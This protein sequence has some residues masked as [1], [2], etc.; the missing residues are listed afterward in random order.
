MNRLLL[1][2]LP[3]FAATMVAANDAA[4]SESQPDDNLR[5]ENG[6][7]NICYND[8][9][10]EAFVEVPTAGIDA[11]YVNSLPAGVGSN[12]L[13]LDRGQLGQTRFVELRV[14]GDRVLM[15]QPNLDYRAISDNPDEVKAV[16]E[17][18][19][20]SVLAAWPIK[21]RKEASVLA[22]ASKFLKADA[23][24]IGLRLQQAEQGQFSV[25]ANRSVILGDSIKAFPANSL[26]ES[27]ITLKGSKPG[28]WVD[29]VTPTSDSLT[30]RMR[31]EWIEPPPPGFEMRPY[32]PRSGAF[33]LD[34]IDF[35]APLN[36]SLHKKVIV[37]HRLQKANPEAARS[38][39]VEP[40][41][42]YVDRGAPEPIRSAL[43]EGA[44]WWAEAFESAGFD[45]AYRV[46]LLPEGVDALDIR[47][48]VIQWVHR[49]TRGWSYGWGVID[50]RTGEIIKGHVS[51]GSQ[52]VRQDQLIAEALTA[53]FVDGDESGKEA[54][55]M[56]LQRLRQLA[57]H[58]VGHTLGLAHNFAASTND[59]ASVM[60]YP[61]PNL[62]LSKN[63]RIDLTRAYASGTAPWDWHAI[64]YSYRQFANDEEQKNGL[65][66][67]LKHSE[68]LAY[69][70][71]ADS[72][73]PGAPAPAGNLWDNGADA[74]ERFDELLSIRR[75]AL[76]RMGDSVIR[77]GQPWFTIESRLVPVY[78]LHRYQMQAVG[79]LIGG[80]Y[81]EYGL[82]GDG[83]PLPK[84]VPRNQQMA[85]IG[86]LLQS[87]DEKS[88]T[89]SD[90]LLAQ[91]QPPP[92]GYGRDREYFT[93]LTGQTFDALAPARAASQLVAQVLLHPQRLQRMLTQQ[94]TDRQL[95]GLQYLLA[96][97]SEEVERQLKYRASA[98]NR[99]VAW[100]LIRE[101]QRA[102]L[103]P[104]L[105]DVARDAVIDALSAL[106]QRAA[107]NDDDPTWVRI[108]A[109]LQTFLDEPN[110]DQIPAR[111]AI[112]PGSPI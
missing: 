68:N 85:A 21:E 9:K 112:P 70:S 1:G 110:A 72:R 33:T 105:D 74:L 22:D 53:P 56:A 23:H 60:D 101:L 54:T 89:L 15:I 45:N 12:D 76:A 52:R 25:D 98:V 107:R 83:T 24:G 20:Q 46:E 35:A 96:E 67:I 73:N 47:Y 92:F 2:V 63:G 42:Y 103:D 48:N 6:F 87:L 57:A 5:C 58:E 36:E 4:D 62:K 111:A 66:A 11:I 17:A 43:M 93:H 39:A 34:Y 29:D 81:Y 71:E 80:S 65:A 26:V 77:Q 40:I 51:L 8:T 69:L 3:L 59:D 108:E 32:H 106:R 49:A 99:T 75:T 95:P 64:N 18:F 97:V 82:R 90:Q 19:A 38:E 79:K 13:G 44:S 86:A 10:G 7:L 37:R 102:A 50:P 31:H 30:V 109:T 100:T 61:H 16:K 104:A 14:I 41:V 88:L 55:A 78:L 27:L 84:A 28:N 91:L 94:Q